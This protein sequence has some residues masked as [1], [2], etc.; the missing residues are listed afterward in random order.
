MFRMVKLL[1]LIPPPPRPPSDGFAPTTPHDEV[2]VFDFTLYR[3]DTTALGLLPTRKNLGGFPVHV[4]N[5]RPVDI[6]RLTGI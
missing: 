2:N 5:P 1:Q 4:S 6:G 3:I